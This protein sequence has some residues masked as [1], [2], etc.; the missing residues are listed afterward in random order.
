VKTYVDKQYEQF[1]IR[2]FS[3]DISQDEL[4]W[5]RDKRNRV[6]LP[7]ECEGWMIQFDNN[8]PEEMLPNVSIFVECEK[9][10]RIIKGKGRLVIRILED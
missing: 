10:H 6:I 5:H 1:I 2:E 7:V 3:Q 8:P 9:Y 4:V